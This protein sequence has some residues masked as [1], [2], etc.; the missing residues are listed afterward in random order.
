MCGKCIRIEWQLAA[1]D[2]TFEELVALIIKL[3]PDIV[4]CV[5]FR[6]MS[7]RDNLNYFKEIESEIAAWIGTSL[8]DC[9]KETYRFRSLEIRKVAGKDRE[10]PVWLVLN[11][12]EFMWLLLHRIIGCGDSGFR[13]VVPYSCPT[14]GFALHALLLLDLKKVKKRLTKPAY[15]RELRSWG[16]YAT[17]L[18]FV[19]ENT[20][21]KCAEGLKIEMFSVVVRFAVPAN[22]TFEDWTSLT[23]IV[24][25]LKNLKII[26]TE[27][28]IEIELLF[29][30]DEKVDPIGVAY[31]H[32]FFLTAF[33]NCYDS[34]INVEDGGSDARNCDRFVLMV[35]SKSFEEF[36]D[37]G[38]QIT[39]IAEH[40]AERIDGTKSFDTLDL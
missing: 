24:E 33:K 10:V 26:E 1:V 13:M 17:S 31:C 40:S 16:D 19:E 9:S 18:R 8:E 21:V 28:Y 27:N 35:T 25:I 5:N 6:K 29:L 7:N 36:R 12:I 30:S 15:T 4:D 3:K 32:W 38:Q 22:M 2:K 11:R 39:T 23:G 34:W 14:S 37:N 20:L